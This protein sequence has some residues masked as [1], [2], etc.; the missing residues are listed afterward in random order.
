MLQT[1]NVNDTISVQMYGVQKG[2]TFRDDGMF[3]LINRSEGV[4]KTLF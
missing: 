1:K 3:G 2:E 4:Q